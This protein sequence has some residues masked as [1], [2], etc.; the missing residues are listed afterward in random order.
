MTA[1]DTKSGRYYPWKADKYVSVTTIIGDGIP[2]P[3][4]NHW[5][6]KNVATL[7]AANRY[8]LSVMD[9]KKAYDWLMKS[10]LADSGGAA[11]LGSNLHSIFQDLSLGLPMP[12]VSTEAFGYV[13]SFVDFMNDHQPKF[14]E[15][16]SAVFSHHGYAGTLDFICEIDGKVV[17]GDYKTGKSV[18]PEA[19]L[20]IAAYRYA[21]FIGRADGR[22][23]PLPSC[24][25]S[26]V[27]HIRPEGYKIVDVD[28]GPQ[29]FD[30]FLSALDVY[31]WITIDSDHVIVR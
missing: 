27:L 28:T 24:D 22:E 11:N 19:A 8:E 16:E 31:R 23:D 21:D 10:R 30:T 5:F 17:I 1:V 26:V 2:K 4:L 20:Q 3:G 7:A 25:R 29:V 12:E 13:T 15:T 14:I 9:E 18:W 6:I